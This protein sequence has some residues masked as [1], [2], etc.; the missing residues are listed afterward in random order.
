[1]VLD[2]IYWVLAPTLNARVTLKVSKLY[3]FNYFDAFIYFNPQPP[4]RS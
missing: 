2:Y 3:K 4:P 1:M